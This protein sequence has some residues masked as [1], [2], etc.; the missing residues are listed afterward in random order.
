LLSI[1]L[2]TIDHRFDQ[3][4]KVRTFLSSMAA[5]LHY[6]A[7]LPVEVFSHISGSLQSEDE[8][9]QR[10]ADLMRKNLLLSA[11]LQKTAALEAENL[12]LRDLLGSS[13]R[14]HD[15]ILIA[16]LIA[17]DLDPFKHQVVINKGSSDGVY[18]GQAVLDANAVMGQVIRV[19]PISATVLMI[20]DASHALPVQV[21][22]SGLRSIANGTGQLDQLELH[23]LPLNSDI[24]V[25][26]L[27]VTSG[28][29]GRF[30]PGYPVGQVSLI[31]KPPGAP[32]LSIHVRPTAHLERARELLLVIPRDSNSFAATASATQADNDN[33]VNEPGLP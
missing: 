23:N 19:S 8:L 13:G 15:Q 6:L 21:N 17:I 14:L 11:R 31:E 4:A 22:R 3:F 30:P 25:G 18:S 24:E 1:A 20:T 16:E 33:P 29:G 5:P 28:L 2:M 10:N 12:R 27:L 26:D 32:F 7:A 9:Q